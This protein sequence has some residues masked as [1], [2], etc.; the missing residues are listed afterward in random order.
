MKVMKSLILI[1]LFLVSINGHASKQMDTLLSQFHNYGITKCDAMIAR[2][3]NIEKIH[4][5]TYFINHSTNKMP[6][7]VYEA[8]LIAVF[9][10]VGDSAKL[11]FSFTQ[12]PNSCELHKRIT[13][14]KSG[15]CEENINGNDWYLA[16]KALDND[17]KFYK[18][19][20][21]DALFAKEIK[22]GNFKACAQEL[23][24]RLIS[25][26]KKLRKAKKQA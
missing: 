3:F 25:K 6:G 17:Y 4:N 10:T 5:W 23:S 7:E 11:D 8:T 19:K 15:G 26:D 2:S 22:V 24:F 20:Y 9:G 21:G 14:T 13:T 18:N 16:E 12:T 1:L